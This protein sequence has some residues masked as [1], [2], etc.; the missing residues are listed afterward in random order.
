[1]RVEVRDSGIGIGSGTREKL[2]KPFS[3]ADPSATRK[4][5][6]TGLGLAICRELVARMGGDIG[7][8]SEPGVGSTFWFTAWFERAPH[9]DGSKGS[10][11][12]PP[13]RSREAPSDGRPARVLLVEDT[14]V[15]AEVVGEI[16]RTGGY[17]FDL[18]TDGLQAV[19]AVRRVAY[20]VVLMDCQLPVLDGYEA[21]RRIRALE[22]SGE[23][24]EDGQDRLRILALTASATVEDQARA[25]EAGMDD[26]ITKPVDASRLLSAIA[27]HAGPPSAPPPSDRGRD[28][29]EG[30]GA[31]ALNLTLALARLQGNRGLLDRIIVHFRSEAAG[32]VRQLRHAVERRD[33]VPLGYA[34]H[35][36]RGQAS[37]LDAELLIRALLALEREAAAESWERATSS[38]LGVERELERVFAELRGPKP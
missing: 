19:E 38:L 8:Q 13:A 30:E 3:Q 4:H 29:A 6:G 15:N 34:A 18:V 32:G 1:V 28:R 24:A 10:R 22:A 25:R 12:R 17:A 5:G 35:R 31:P 7:V 36:L 2:F 33:K 26:H 20:D 14:P 27:R 9:F 16:L 21:S 11:K 23:V 37:S